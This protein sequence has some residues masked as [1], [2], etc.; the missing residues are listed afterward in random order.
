MSAM[1]TCSIDDGHPSDMKMAEL[2]DK[3]SL[4]GTFFI[5]IRNREGHSVMNEAQIREI[6]GQFEI[7]SHT[8]DHYYLTN[9]N[10]S[11][12]S[13]QVTEGKR[14]LEE[15]I[16]K[17]VVGFCY[18]GGKYHDAHLKIVRSA[19]FE[20]ARTTMNLCFDA[21][22]CRFELP[23]TIQ[24]YPHLRS[25]YLRNFVR[26][27]NWNQRIDGLILAL[28]HNNWIER[29]YALFDYSCQQ[30]RV[31][32]IWAHS[33][34]ID[35]LDAWSEVDR[36]FSHVAKKITMENRLNNQQLVRKEFS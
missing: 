8:Y 15:F 1:F 30:E 22:H 28:H 4:N 17:S 9:I 29:L 27:R 11:E 13:R 24:F 10:L 3:N 5:P 25:V 35:K 31:F 2:L 19:G 7:G 20:Y 6:A 16:G 33:N 23:T 32:H 36:F 21:G 12:A 34:D 18:P 14:K 26:A